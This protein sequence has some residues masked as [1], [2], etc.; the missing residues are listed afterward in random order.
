MSSLVVSGDTSGT[1]TIAAPAVAGS[2]TLTLPVATD[3]LVGKATTDTLTNK[4]IVATQLTGTVA[5]ARMPAG[6]VIQVV[7]Q[8]YPTAASAA[9]QTGSTYSAS[10]FT[11]TITPSNSSNKI[12]AFF[13]STM[14]NTVSNS[15]M[16]VKMM[17]N[18]G[19]AGFTNTSTGIDIQQYFNVIST[20]AY[21]QFAFSFAV[22][23]SPATTSSTI[24]NPHFYGSVGGP[25]GTAYLGGRSTDGLQY[26]TSTITLME[27]VA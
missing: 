17:R 22:L 8:I 3:T 1:I 24:Y 2:S 13:T 18:I 23:D 25:S 9:N 14:G 19:S 12:L 21:L 10:G 5:A 16:S 15:G 7:Q 27:V 11:A 6:S 26:S 4:S 20:L